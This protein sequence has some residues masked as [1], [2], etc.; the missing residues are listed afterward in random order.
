[1]S[2]WTIA[3]FTFATDV[4][5]A[6]TTACTME[7]APVCWE[8]EV[9]C[10]KEPCL[11]IQQTFGNTCMANAAN[12]KNIIQWEC[13]TAVIPWSDKDDHGCIWS[14]WY[15]WDKDLQQCTRPWEN[16][17]I[18]TRAFE[19]G[20]TKFNTEKTFMWNA[21]LTREQAA[22]M[23][24]KT[25]EKMNVPAWTVKQPS[26][27]CEWL[28]KKNINS[29]LLESAKLACTK[30]LLKWSKEGNFMPQKT[31]TVEEMNIILDRLST[32]IPSLK[33]SVSTLL[34]NQYN[35]IFTRNEFVKVLYEMS[36]NFIEKTEKYTQY[37]KDLNIARDLW[38][39]KGKNT[40][41]ITQRISCFCMDDYTRPINYKVTNWVIEKQSL[42]YAD[43][44]TPLAKD[45]TMDFYTVEKAFELIDSAIEEHVA[46]LTV[47]YDEVTGY[48]KTIYIDYNEMIADEEKH[49]S[50]TIN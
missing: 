45:F 21:Y 39:Q 14:A 26:G 5:N 46:N 19:S 8:V 18:I 50:F 49:Y 40:Y 11:P 22:K 7:Y 38:K 2:L 36:K 23:L 32:F 1:M 27:T 25:I 42:T 10:I 48:P 3:S 17:H 9:Q 47:S 41:N 12:A 6:I 30:W 43:N 16:K 44:N 24:M 34:I 15:S 20:V 31:I 35:P 37:K 4:T 13:V 28:D 29:S 33:N